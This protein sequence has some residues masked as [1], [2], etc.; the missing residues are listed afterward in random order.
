MKICLVG[1]GLIAEHHARALRNLDDVHF[2]WLVGRRAEP[3]RE[4]AEQWGF[5]HQTLE[6]DEALADDSLDAVVIT[7]PNGLH[8]PQATAALNAGKHV[9]LEIPMAMNLADAQQLADLAR[10]VNRTLMICHTM[11][12]FPAFTHL[13]RLVE[14]GQLQI[15]QFI[16][17]IFL[18]RRTN[19]TADGK[20]R[21]WTDNILWHH[22]AHYVDLAM[23]IS[24]C[25][26][27]QR[28]SYHFG[29]DFNEQGTMDM[30]LTMT[31][32]N[33][34]IATVSHS[35]FAPRLQQ[36]IRVIGHEDWFEWKDGTL[37]D[38][39]GNVIIPEYSI[40]ELADQDVEFV[41]SVRE[42]RPPSITPETIL[43]TMR[44]L[45]DAQ[46]ILDD[47]RIGKQQ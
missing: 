6:L 3:T 23:W 28:L 40:V 21:S 29:P 10:R 38:F 20:T 9:L 4:F 12:F 45:A 37:C 19:V 36:R 41:S 18:Q 2:R 47:Q 35:Y 25:F 1:Y 39:E 27:V 5:A 43:P 22:A 44:V 13:R 30:S 11:R 14:E 31:L 34:T 7:S 8:A 15:A 42:K 33:G 32:A 16:G 17:H 26:E 24:N 46:A